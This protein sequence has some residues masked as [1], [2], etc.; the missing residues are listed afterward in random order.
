[1]INVSLCSKLVYFKRDFGRPSIKLVTYFLTE[2]LLIKLLVHFVP[3]M[4][5]N[6]Y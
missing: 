2:C 5:H 6:W 1:M 4:A 3:R